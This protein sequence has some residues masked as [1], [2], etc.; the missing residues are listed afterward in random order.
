M[1]RRMRAVPLRRHGVHA[2]PRRSSQYAATPQMETHELKAGLTEADGRAHL[3][4]WRAEA[5]MSQMSKQVRACAAALSE[6]RQA[7]APLCS[8]VV[9]LEGDRGDEQVCPFM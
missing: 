9:S 3:S 6:G 4:D 7:G 5:A 2:S 1:R 8:C